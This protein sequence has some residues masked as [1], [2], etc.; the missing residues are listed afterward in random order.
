MEISTLID[1]ERNVRSHKV[2]GLI[3][4][5]DLKEKL[6]AFYMSPDYDPDMNALWDLREADF[7]SVTSAEVESLMEM[8]KEHWGQG[9]KSKAALIVSKDLDYGLSRMV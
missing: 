6:L 1:K 7:S 2:K 8:V 3:S 5:R 9:G 4:V